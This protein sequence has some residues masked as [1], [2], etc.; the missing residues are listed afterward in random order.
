MTLFLSESAQDVVL[1]VPEVPKQ[2]RLIGV[3]RRILIVWADGYVA[4]VKIALSHLRRQN[5]VSKNSINKL[6]VTHCAGQLCIRWIKF[7]DTRQ[8]QTDKQ[9]TKTDERSLSPHSKTFSILQ[10]PSKARALFQ[11]WPSPRRGISE[12]RDGMK[13]CQWGFLLHHALW[14][15]PKQH[16]PQQLTKAVREDGS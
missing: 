14:N 2:I 7:D 15:T 13:Q 5:T 4:D 6:D 1:L 16:Y 9:L 11:K 12:P 10:K 3:L 8:S